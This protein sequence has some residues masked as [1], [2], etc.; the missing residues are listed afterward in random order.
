MLTSSDLPISCMLFDLD[1]TL[2][3]TAPDLVNALNAVLHQEGLTPYPLDQ[4]RPTV[5]HGTVAMLNHAFGNSQPEIDF[6]RRQQVFL[7]YYLAN[8]CVQSQL[9]TGMSLLL[10]T[11]QTKG[12]PWGVVTNKPHYLTVPLMRALGLVEQASSIVSGD[13]LSVAKP[14]PEPLLLAAQQCGVN[15]TECLYIGDAQRDI[16]AGQRA[17]MRTVVAQYG[18]LSAADLVEDWQADFRIQ[19][20]IELLRFINGTQA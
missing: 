14:H 20:P 16:I 4:I 1:G 12:I 5:S 13:T 6:K 17:G 2:V 3:D 10:N 18:Y 7:D 19:T 8:I 15:P 9:F 11:L